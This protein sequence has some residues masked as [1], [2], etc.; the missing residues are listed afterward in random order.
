MGPQ[1]ALSSLSRTSTNK[2]GVADWIPT[3]FCCYEQ[4]DGVAG[5]KIKQLVFDG[6]VDKRRPVKCHTQGKKTIFISFVQVE[7]MT[8]KSGN[9]PV[10]V[11]YLSYP[12]R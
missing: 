1:V 5:V 12:D 8:D 3:V 10:V 7:V 2:M 9:I 11:S 6:C 4:L